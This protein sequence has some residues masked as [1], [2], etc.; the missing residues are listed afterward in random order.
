MATHYWAPH[1]GGIETVAREQARLLRGLGWQVGVFTTRLGEDAAQEADDPG[2]DVTVYRYRCINWAEHQIRVPV[3]VP[4]LRM[5]AD[6][7]RHAATSDVVLAHGHCYPASVYAARA[8]AVNRRPLVVM[9]HSPFVDYPLP[10][11][12]L[13]HGVDATIGRRVLHRAAMVIC[14]SKHVECY[15][16]GIAPR[17]RTQTIY[18]GVDTGVFRP[19][20][21]VATAAPGLRVLTV[22]RLVPRNGVDVLI[23]AWRRAGLS[24]A[25]LVIVGGGAEQARLKRLAAGLASVSF[26]GWV[27]QPELPCLYRSADIVVVPS[28]YGE[29]FGLVAAEALACGV[30][31]IATTGGATG[32]VVRHG[33]DG[34]IVE[35]ADTEALA[36]AITRLAREPDL[37]ARMKAAARERAPRLGWTASIRKLE[38]VLDAAGRLGPGAET[39]ADIVPEEISP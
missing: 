32:E 28:L 34:F 17:A 2:G 9:Q 14:V 12:A 15:V 6:L 1:V 39:P 37:L 27:T 33:I 4:S 13:E 29:G 8:A 3:P 31:V 21:P 30:P 20:G 16:R 5:R 22:R 38:A 36:G 18:S 19:D 24:G 7:A 25:E 11:A 35:A 23:E 26:A 10:L